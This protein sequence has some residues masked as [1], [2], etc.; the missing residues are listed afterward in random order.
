MIYALTALSI[1]L[2]GSCLYF[3]RKTIDANAEV[4]SLYSENLRLQKIKR[5]FLTNMSHELRTPITA[6]KGFTELLQEW[7][8]ADKLP[9]RYEK[10]LAIMKRNEILLLELVDSIL[11]YSKLRSG[12]PFSSL[13]E[14][15]EPISAV[16][17]V[18]DSFRLNAEEKSLYL[19]LEVGGEM[20]AKL[21][22]NAQTL[23]QVLRNLLQNAIKFTPTGG[24]LVRVKYDRPSE[25]LIIDTLDT[26]VG[27]EAKN[28][29]HIFTPFYHAESTAARSFGGVGLGL[30]ISQMLVQ[31][32]EGSIEVRSTVGR[33]SSFRLILPAQ[34]PKALGEASQKMTEVFASAPG[35]SLL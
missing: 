1:L 3:Y 2:G 26:G 20:P 30:S 4:R 10:S 31:Q 14:T 17:E 33:G 25:K 12:V 32:A 22:T 8:Q 27:I 9:H 24:I 23:K 7:A 16:R 34:G 18:I 15:V 13:I 35:S 28:V 21:A 11:S 6:L 29:K 19:K 5:E